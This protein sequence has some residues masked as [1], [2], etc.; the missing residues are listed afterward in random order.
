MSPLGTAVLSVG[1]LLLGWV[2]NEISHR[3]RMRE[4]GRRHLARQHIGLQVSALTEVQGVATNYATTARW[5][6][7]ATWELQRRPNDDDLGA[8]VE[9]LSVE[10]DAQ[11]DELFGAEAKVDDLRIRSYIDYLEEM[12]RQFLC[13]PGEQTFGTETSRGETV[14]WEQVDELQRILWRLNRFI[15]SRLLDLVGVVDPETPPYRGE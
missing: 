5:L 14:L 7:F 10:L 8:E 3:W 9:D 12:A 4:E 13:W 11:T 15:G 2:L 6:L 1:T